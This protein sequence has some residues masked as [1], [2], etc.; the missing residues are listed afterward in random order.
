ML[1]QTFALS[2]LLACVS[3]FAADVELM[4]TETRSI[5][6]PQ[7]QSMRLSRSTA[8][9]QTKMIT[10]LNIKLSTTAQANLLTREQDDNMAYTT[11]VN[12]PR[13]KQLGMAGVP[14]LDQGAHGACV[15]FATTAA[16]DAAVFKSDA[17]SQLCQLELGSYLEKVGNNPSGWDGSFGHI[18]LNQ[19]DTFGV[20][21]K[22]KQESEGCAGL[23]AYP[24]QSETPT[25]V[26][27]PEVFHQMI[28][29]TT[30]PQITWFPILHV[31][32]ALSIPVDS[33][34]ILT[35]VKEALNA[36]DRVAFGSLLVDPEEG[37]AGAVGTYHQ[38]LDA[39]VLTAHL[40]YDMEHTAN[41]AGH[42]MVITGYDDDAVAK[43]AD[44]LKHK[45]LLTLRNSWGSSIG[46]QGNFYMSYDYFKSLVIEAHQIRTV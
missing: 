10:L 20:I 24:T 1:K 18:V 12:L 8:L 45:G 40:R 32:E 33:Q 22:D 29:G 30:Q 2:C 25:N 14:V 44:G 26:M 39:W 35:K 46:D 34:R 23:K 6:I 16:I 13:A 11:E 42:E 21:S 38:S 19:I 17:I 43:D 9:P 28:A 5:A 27:T 15:T 41:F 4:G 7:S 36:G 3:T 37:V 31:N